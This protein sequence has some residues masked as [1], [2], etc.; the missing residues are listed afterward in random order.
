MIASFEPTAV[1][2]CKCKQENISWLSDKGN[3][4]TT[5]N[6]TNDNDLILCDHHE[7]I[8]GHNGLIMNTDG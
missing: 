2:W 8:I 1:E 7:A 6:N 3:I 4:P 5:S